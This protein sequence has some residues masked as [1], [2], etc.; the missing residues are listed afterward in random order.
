MWYETL[1]TLCIDFILQIFFWFLKHIP[2]CFIKVIKVIK[3]M[4]N[5]ITPKI[6]FDFHTEF[7]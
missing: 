1:F 3:E 5:A 4:L 7:C 6:L 2:N